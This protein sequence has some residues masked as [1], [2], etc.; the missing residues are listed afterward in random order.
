MNLPDDP[1][2]KSEEDAKAALHKALETIFPGWGANRP[3]PNLEPVKV[4]IKD[5]R[6]P[7]SLILERRAKA[8]VGFQLPP[9]S[10]PVETLEDLSEPAFEGFTFMAD[11]WDLTL[12][13]RAQVVN[14]SE[15]EFQKWSLEPS[16]PISEEVLVR[17]SHLMSIYHALVVMI[18]D[19]IQVNAWMKR[20]SQ[21]KLFGGGTPLSFL[22]KG[23]T[24]AFK[25]VHQLLYGRMNVW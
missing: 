16:R 6:N 7:L 18:P 12:P 10:N 4:E 23:P 25:A 21:N 9:T 3:F 1:K 22:I 8:S 17:V 14:L 11:R 20:P 19:E 2:P 24:S 5:E 15:A 13:E